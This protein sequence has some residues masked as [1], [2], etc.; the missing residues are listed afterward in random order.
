MLH[1]LVE[2]G[3]FE[4]LEVNNCTDFSTTEIYV[5]RLLTKNTDLVITQKTVQYSVEGDSGTLL[6][7]VILFENTMTIWTV[8]FAFACVQV[9]RL[10][11][12]SAR[13]KT[14]SEE[15]ERSEEELK[16]EKRK[17]QREVSLC[18]PV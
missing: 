12:L 2:M 17:L 15:L 13:Y 3:L 18:L 16:L 4:I 1:L 7:Y 11:A 9:A 8:N 6:A 10:D 14:Q 5:L